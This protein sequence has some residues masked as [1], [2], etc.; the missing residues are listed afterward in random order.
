MSDHM[1]EWI[2][3]YHDG[4]LKP[5]RRA[6]VEA[7]LAGCAECRREMV[8]L[9]ALSGLLGA[10]PAPMPLT[11]EEVFVGQ[12]LG[13]L[14][15]PVEPFWRRAA[16]TS[17][18]YTPLGLFAAWAFFQAVIAVT[19]A[20]MLA[21]NLFPPVEQA[22]SAL[23]PLREGGADGGVFSWLGRAWGSLALPRPSGLV[24]TVGW[25]GPLALFDIAL[26]GLFAVLFLAWL[27]GFWSHHKVRVEEYSVEFTDGREPSN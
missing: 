6:W 15:R 8:E 7:H 20:L 14:P 27:A 24:E 13:R 9:S 10:D 22:L 11:A 21:M 5:D 17:L 26:A 2:A 25:A 19:G 18:R 16:R 1:T 23:L 4:E 12:V 3:A